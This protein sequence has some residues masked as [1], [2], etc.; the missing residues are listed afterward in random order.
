MSEWRSL[1][2]GEPIGVVALSGP[3]DA[4]RLDS[5]VTALRSWS[6]PVELASNLRDR[7]GYLA[8]SDDARLGGLEEL[9]DRGVRTLIAA[10]GGYGATRLLDR[11]PWPR[12][13]DERVRLIGFSDLTALLNPLSSSAV[14]V[15]GPMAAA[16]LDRPGN[17]RRLHE[18][19]IGRLVGETLFRVPPAAVVRHGRTSGIAVGGNL[20]LLLSL[21]G[22]PWQP[23]FDDRVLFLEE[24]AEPPYRIDRMLTQL[25]GCGVLNRVSAVVCGR[26]HRCRPHADCTERCIERLLESTGSS[27]PVLVGLPFGHGA[28]NLAFPIG[29]RV[30][31]DTRRNRVL[32]SP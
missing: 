26:L 13:R 9:L 22:T 7:D 24:V 20:S 10:R 2:P 27:T 1:E 19:L 15:H 11:L 23:D 25:R 6:H 8:G 21:M 29:A 5:G 31:V 17:A 32:W 18:V 3:V 4:V 30:T 12:M 14:Q 16:G 28:V